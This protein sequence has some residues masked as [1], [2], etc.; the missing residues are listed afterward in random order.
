MSR[1]WNSVDRLADM[2]TEE[3]ESEVQNIREER[4]AERE[5]SKNMTTEER[6]AHINELRDN[7]REARESRVSPY[8]QMSMGLDTTEIVCAEG[9]EL[10][11]KISN[12]LP[13]CLNPD[14]VV[15]LLDRGIV[16]YPE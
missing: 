15:M 3:R 2:T 6:Q 9:L 4:K 13:R 7:A 8:E 16:S 10:V 11:I 5:A 14:T 12:G 1:V